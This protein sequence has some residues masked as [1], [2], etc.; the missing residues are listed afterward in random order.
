MSLE[1]I[2]ELLA[3]PEDSTVPQKPRG[4]GSVEVVSRLVI[5]D[6]VELTLDPARAGLV[7]EAVRE[8]FNQVTTAYDQIRKKHEVKKNG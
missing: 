1:R 7:P 4:R 5:D 6:G 2:A 3:S 8:L